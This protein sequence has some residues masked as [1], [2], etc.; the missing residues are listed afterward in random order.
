MI[1]KSRKAFVEAVKKEVWE[2]EERQR[3]RNRMDDLQNQIYR[4]REELYDLQMKTDPEYKR[5]NTPNC[6]C[7]SEMATVPKNG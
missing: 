4:L 2:E 5:R 3:Q 1:F 7:G 6:N